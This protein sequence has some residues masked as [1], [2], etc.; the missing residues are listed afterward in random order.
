VHAID[1]GAQENARQAVWDGHGAGAVSISGPAADLSRQTT[2]DMAV[3][4]R[5]RIDA[6]ATAPASLSIAC[7]PG[8]GAG[9][10]VTSLVSA[11]ASDAWR[12]AEIKLSCFKAG[13]ADMTRITSPFR[14]AT[15]GKLGLTF[16]EIRLAANEGGAICPPSR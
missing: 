16:S 3:F 15:N 9:V 13:G 5:Y 14:L 8:C 4:V 12:T 11:P 7:G 1:A 10:D 6:P 2:G